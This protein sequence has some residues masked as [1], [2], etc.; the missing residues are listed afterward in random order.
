MGEIV[1]ILAL[2]TGNMLQRV[3]IKEPD[4]S[5]IIANY[6]IAIEFDETK[7]SLYFNIQI[8]DNL[9]VIIDD[10]NNTTTAECE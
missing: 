9:P 3:L 10:T 2:N 8:L 1:L 5:I 6:Q 4:E 7:T